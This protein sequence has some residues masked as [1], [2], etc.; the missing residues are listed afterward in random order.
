MV[1]D[2]R[3]V[4]ERQKGLTLERN[5]C[6]VGTSSSGESKDMNM[7]DEAPYLASPVS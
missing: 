1:F 2:Q 4:P 6:H 3:R 5:S 7:M